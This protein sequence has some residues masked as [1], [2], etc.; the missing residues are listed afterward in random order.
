M[1]LGPEPEAQ[2][3]LVRRARLQAGRSSSAHAGPA[4]RFAA[5]PRRPSRTRRRFSPRSGTTSHTVASATRSSSSCSA[6]SGPRPP[7]RVPGRACGPRPPRRARRKG[8]PPGRGGRSGNP[9]S[10]SAGWWWSVTTTSMPAA[11]GLLDLVDRRDR[12]V[13]RDQQAGSSGGQALHGGRAQ[14]VALLEPAR[15]VPGRIGPER[16]QALHEDRRGRDAVHVVVPVNHDPAAAPDV[17]Q[18]QLANLPHRPSRNG[19]C[20][21]A[22]SRNAARRSGVLVPP[23]NED[24][25]R[26][27]ETPEL[28]AEALRP[29]PRARADRPSSAIPASRHSGPRASAEPPRISVRPW[30][31]EP[32]PVPVGDAQGDQR[33]GNPISACSIPGGDCLGDLQARRR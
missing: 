14:P 20:S 29:R 32:R 17:A 4:A 27:G 30:L 2:R 21:S 25:R 19:S 5:A 13:G 18:D 12:T 23:A 26:C 11:R 16:A 33:A 24:S 31:L 7:C 9:G 15:D 22:P 8:S 6:G 10:V 28:G 3:A 1:S